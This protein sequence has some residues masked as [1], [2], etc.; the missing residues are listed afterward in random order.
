MGLE[1]RLPDGVLTAKTGRSRQLE[2]P[3]QHL[4]TPVWPGLLRHRDDRRRHGAP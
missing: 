3:E 1:E 4:A 2:P